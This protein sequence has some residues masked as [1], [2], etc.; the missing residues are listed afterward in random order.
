MRNL[1]FVYL[2]LYIFFISNVSIKNFLAIPFKTINLQ[3][4]ESSKDFFSKIFSNDIYVNITL[5]TPKQIVKT[6]IKMEHDQFY[7]YSEGYSHDKSS[8]YK[9]LDIDS[10]SNFFYLEEKKS[11][12]LFYFQFFN[13]YNELIKIDEDNEKEIYKK[14][15]MN[16]ILIKNLEKNDFS[17]KWTTNDKKSPLLNNYGLIGLQY[18]NFNNSIFFIKSLKQ[19]N[20]INN[21]VFSLFFINDKINSN[22]NINNDGYFIVGEDCFDTNNEKNIIKYAKAEQRYGFLKWDI[23]F[24]EIF[25][26]PN[27]ND[28]NRNIINKNHQVELVIDKPYIIGTDDYQ[29]FIHE[30]F[31]EDLINKGVC[32]KKF[33]S[34]NTIYYGYYCDVES[35]LFITKKFPELYLYSRELEEIF[36]LNKNDLFFYDINYNNKDE[37][38]CYFMILFINSKISLLKTRWTLGVPFFKKY[39]F[40]FDYDKKSVGF[41]N[42]SI[43][44]DVQND[45]E[46]KTKNNNNNS[47]VYDG[48]NNKIIKI[49]FIFILIILL[50]VLMG[51]FCKKYANSIKRKKK[52]NELI[53]DNYGY[54]EDKKKN[55]NINNNRNKNNDYNVE[56]VNK[57]NI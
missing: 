15:P 12:E 2:K 33:I 18:Q 19:S 52:V 39:R 23:I 22:N 17:L 45:K 56:L 11:E 30:N 44:L 34:I 29:S 21:Y 40:L 57:N 53:D 37:H 55:L 1:F 46:D 25:S 28:K 27:D 42:Q 49:I 14:I 6:L 24:D 31:F 50:I 38:F 7:I 8:T 9:N 41:Y 5:G 26:Y 48:D 20:E 35:E 43:F 47:Y 10:K 3:Y 54:K 13:S 4:N 32:H 36:I 51:I 16:F